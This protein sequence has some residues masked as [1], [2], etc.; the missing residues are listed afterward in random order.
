MKLDRKGWIVLA[1]LVAAAGQ[2]AGVVS[3][4]P[5]AT[6]PTA[7]ASSKPTIEQFLRIRT[8]GSAT[9]A[10]DGS[11]YVRDWPD[12]IFQLY[13]AKP[14]TDLRPGKATLE[15]LTNFPDGLG[16]YSIS[17]DGSRILL[18]HAVGGNENFQISVLD[19]STG[20]ISPIANNPKVQYAVNTWLHD[21]SGFVYSGNQDSPNDFYLYL[22]NFAKGE[23]TRIL[24]KEG[25]W[26]AGDVSKDA[27]RVLVGKYNSASD[28]LVY[29]LTAGSDALVDLTILPEGG[30]T[31]SNEVV[32][33]MPGD[34]SV[35]LLSDA[36]DGI[37]RLYMKDLKTG[38]VTSPVPSLQ[39]FEVDGA[40][41]NLEK[42]MLVV[43]TNEDGY[44]VPHAFSLPDFKPVALPEAERGVVGLGSFRDGT[45]VWSLNNARTPGLAYATK[46]TPGGSGETRQ[47]T[48]ADTQ[49][50]DLSRF[51]LPDLIKYK[52]FDG[53]E[54][55]AFVFFPPGYDKASKKPI[56]FIALYHGGPE[57]QH[58]P[59]FSAQQQ[60]LLSEGFGIIL[61]NVRGS[62]GYGRDFLMMDD[63][64]KRWDSVKDGVAAAKWLVDNGY[65][66]PGMI[67]TFG[68]SYGGYMSVA[69][70]V[71]DSQ[72]AEQTGR[73]K[74][75]GAGVNIVGITNVKTFLEKTSGYRR[76]LREVEYG[77]LTDPEFLLS[78]SPIMKLEHIRVPMFIA[79]GFNDP[80]VPVEEAMQLSVALKDRAFEQKRMDLMPQLLVFPDEGHG[81]AKLENRLLF[82]RQTASF[83]KRTIGAA[84]PTSPDK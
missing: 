63:Y 11:L 58:R 36:R 2:C 27:T 61:P 42:T 3:A 26:A 38:S 28:S 68:G 12:G 66:A 33:Y 67:S 73:S 72:Q 79:H 60:Y 21:G 43:V 15:R 81:F 64:K 16:D 59:I 83:L 62:S 6:S 41:F 19:P 23:S 44:G 45:L 20:K 7:S 17:P 69:C 5:A 18:T 22:W 37:K 1:A 13:R 4:Q 80:R 24:A 8:P 53:L 10:P 77:P 30:G 29:E 70:L 84:K 40:G 34:E 14:G 56:P 74:Y 50:I 54:V 57:G 65:S 55:P 49:G 35:L 82:A 9:L 48:W 78:V 52:S 32:G 51:P 46:V 71:E 25:S 39:K 75:F 31:A 47:L 76:K